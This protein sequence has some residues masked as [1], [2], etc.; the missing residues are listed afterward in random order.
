MRDANISTNV[1]LSDRLGNK[2]KPIAIKYEAFKEMK[3]MN[4][5][6]SPQPRK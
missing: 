3:P 2:A 6:R 1:M 4:S 5:S